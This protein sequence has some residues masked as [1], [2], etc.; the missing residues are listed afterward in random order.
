MPDETIKHIAT[1]FPINPEVLKPHSKIQRPRS[2][3]KEYALNTS[4]HGIPSIARSEDIPSR[5]FWSISSTIFTGIMMYFIVQAIRN[6]FEY[7]SQTSVSVIVEW[8]QAFPA[9]TICNYCPLRYDR[10]I[11]PYFDY[12]KMLNLTNT[13]DTN[14]FTYEQSLYIGN[15]L[16]DK[17]NR[18]ETLFDYFF[19]LDTMLMS[20][21]YNGIRCS[22]ANFTW[23]ISVSFGIC[24]T[25]NAKLKNVDNGGI[26]YNSDNGG[27]GLLELRLYTH[28]H[29]YVPYLVLGKC[30]LTLLLS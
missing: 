4:T 3:I 22:P 6:Y 26:R 15:F 11:G 20:C 12:L 8:P 30:Q 10:F 17:L 23:F 25:I 7:P 13:T 29:Q 19:S 14:N 21:S 27:F 1:V 9:V 18:N 2:I 28:Q 24:Y 5:I 16:I